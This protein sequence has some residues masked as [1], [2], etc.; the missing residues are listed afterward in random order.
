MKTG[1]SWTNQSILEFL[2]GSRGT[3][4]IKHRTGPGFEVESEVKTQ[5]P[6]F[7]RSVSR[8]RAP[9]ALT[10]QQRDALPPR[11]GWRCGRATPH[12]RRFLQLPTRWW[13]QQL[14]LW[15]GLSVTREVHSFSIT[16]RRKV[17][18]A[19][20]GPQ[21]ATWVALRSGEHQLGANPPN[22]LGTKFMA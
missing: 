13:R 2:I 21:A 12:C 11:G 8:D 10:P 22:P 4:L 7:S 5:L 20:S 17:L 18:S 9:A 19:R 16:S 6:G 15:A 1:S 3:N 14:A